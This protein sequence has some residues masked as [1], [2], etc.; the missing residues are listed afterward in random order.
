MFQRPH[1]ESERNFSCWHCKDCFHCIFIK[2]TENLCASTDLAY[3]D[4]YINWC[5]VSMV[6]SFLN[7]IIGVGFSSI[8]C[9]LKNCLEQCLV[10]SSFLLNVCPFVKKVF[11]YWKTKEYAFTVSFQQLKRTA[12]QNEP[13]SFPRIPVL[14]PDETHPSFLEDIKLAESIHADMF[15]FTILH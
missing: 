1:Y 10:H 4:K 3:S 5:A 15:S 14:L 13:P 8:S 7:W 2:H 9:T 6:I 12:V 11:F